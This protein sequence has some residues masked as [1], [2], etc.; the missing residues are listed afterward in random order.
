MSILPEHIMQQVMLFNSHP[1]A[2]IFKES[3][4]HKY[5]KLEGERKHGNPFDRGCA[6]AYYRR[7]PYPHYWVN[8]NGRNGGTIV[9]LTEE[10]EEAYEVGYVGWNEIVKSY[11]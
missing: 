8:G 4:Y 5:K 1:V 2:D 10:E 6:D 7:P 11:K 9:E 3:L